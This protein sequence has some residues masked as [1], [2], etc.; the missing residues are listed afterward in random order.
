VTIIAASLSVGFRQPKLQKHPRCEE[1][2]PKGDRA[3]AEIAQNQSDGAL[4]CC[5]GTEEHVQAKID[6]KNSNDPQHVTGSPLPAC[7]TGLEMEAR[8]HEHVA[9]RSAEKRPRQGE[10]MR[11]AARMQRILRP[12]RRVREGGDQQVD[13]P[14]S[15]DDQEGDEKSNGDL[16]AGGEPLQPGCGLSLA[17]GEDHDNRQ[18]D[19][20]AY[21]DVRGEVDA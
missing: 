17:Q 6:R 19:Q 20:P 21:Q 5:Q 14:A 1:N 9:G 7:T 2:R 10:V 13:D 11:D 3:V 4:I 8:P 16:T 12:P 18:T 15:Q